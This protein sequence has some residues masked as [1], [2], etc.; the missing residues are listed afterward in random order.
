VKNFPAAS[1]LLF[2]SRSEKAVDRNGCPVFRKDFAVKGAKRRLRRS[3][4]LDSK[5][6][7]K[8]SLAIAIDGA[9]RPGA[10]SAVAANP[11]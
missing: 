4:I 11:S 10:A 1:L 8:L 6:L 7:S 9:V 3:K 2:S 5:I